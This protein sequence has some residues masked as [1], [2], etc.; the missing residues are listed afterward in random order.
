MTKWE[1]ATS[2]LHIISTVLLNLI[3]VI[4]GT[5]FGYTTESL[6]I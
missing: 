3:L 1:L 4:F 2:K 5:H 6:L